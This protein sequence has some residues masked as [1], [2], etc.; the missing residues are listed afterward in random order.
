MIH[1]SSLSSRLRPAALALALLAVAG[2]SNAQVFSAP[3]ADFKGNVRVASP[4]VLPG[5]EIELA[6]AGFTPG[7]KITLLRG[8][9]VLNAQPYVADAEGKFTARLAIPAD[10]VAGVHPVVVR[11]AGPDA[12]SVL[13]LKVSRE[14]PPA[15]QD[16]F[17]V[18]GRKLVAGLY[19][20]AYSAKN[21]ALFVTSAVG[22]PPVT[23]SELV[24][25][26]PKT[27][28]IVARATPP[29]APA[30]A[31]RPGQEPREGGLHAVYGV[32]VDDANGTVWV[33]NTRQ[34]T[35][36]V[37]RQSDLSLVKQYPVDAVPHSRD[38]IVDEKR[39]R[40][41]ASAT[42]K[43]FVSVFDTATLEQL[44]N[45]EIASTL[46]GKDFVPMSLEL[47]AAAGKL[48]TVSMGTGEIAIIDT[49]AN[50]VEKV[51]VVP[52]ARAASG[53]AFDPENKRVLVASQGS[54]NLLI[55]DPAEGRVVHD[56]YVG[57][58]ALNVAWEPVGK[59]AWVSNRAAGTVTAVDANGAIVANLDGGSFPN[60]VHED[61]KGNVF[62]I[63]KSR[64]EDDATGDRVTRISAK[65]KRR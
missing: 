15:G 2:L 55:V 24:K 27:L 3:D 54:D 40:A 64:G 11:V 62:A 20:S 43:N 4:L 61:G 37:Y 48:Y 49:A 56:V 7:Q 19:Q 10:A 52:N 65:K 33:T 60:H 59:L 41:Y 21:D 50:R 35:V 22:R 51:F 25:V 8:D 44:P 36:A 45:I 6:G 13:E 28:E 42:G 16:R 9:S 26:D 17:E 29:Q 38:V 12:A 46:W 63:N 53:V 34:N 31:P 39:G 5:N 32:A 1:A 23:R 18:T 14:L 57:A 47:D 58:G 30:P